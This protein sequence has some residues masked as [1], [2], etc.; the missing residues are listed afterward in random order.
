M[1][2]WRL[3]Y[4]PTNRLFCSNSFLIMNERLVSIV[5]SNWRWLAVGGGV[6]NARSGRGISSPA[7]S[8]RK[9]SLRNLLWIYGRGPRDINQTELM[10]TEH[11]MD[12][13]SDLFASFHIRLDVES[14]ASYCYDNDINLLAVSFC[15][16]LIDLQFNVYKVHNSMEY[17]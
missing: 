14:A 16:V 4:Q 5:K 8:S 6:T 13:M 17:C 2:E 7:A 10:I 15:Q 3:L 1:A 11:R 12:F 9:N